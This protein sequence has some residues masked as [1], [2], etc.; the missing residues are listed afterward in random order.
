[1]DPIKASSDPAIATPTKKALA[2]PSSTPIKGESPVPSDDQFWTPTPEKPA[3]RSRWGCGSSIAFSVNEVRQAALGLCKKD[4]GINEKLDRD[5]TLVEN[6]L[7]SKKA[8]K[9]SSSKAKDKIQ[10]PRK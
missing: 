7:R 9:L 3:Q 4:V 6:Q 2:F 8:V 1:M 5:L 10:L